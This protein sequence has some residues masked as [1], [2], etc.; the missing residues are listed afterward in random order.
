MTFRKYHFGADGPPDSGE[1]KFRDGFISIRS[2][3]GVADNQLRLFAF[4][5]PNQTGA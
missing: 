3:K 5:L 1:S 4:Y 2:I